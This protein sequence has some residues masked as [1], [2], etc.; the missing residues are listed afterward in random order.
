MAK[1]LTFIMQHEE[2]YNWC[3]AAVA[4]SVGDY[5]TQAGTWKQ[6]AVANLELRRNDCCAAGGDGPCNIYGYLASALNRVH[7]LQNWAIGQRVA[8][9][10]VVGEIDGGRPVCV[11]VAWRGGGA[12]FVA[13]TG[14]SDPD[15]TIAH[16]L[17]QDPL[18][19]YHDIAWS[20]FLDYYK[21]TGLHQGYWTDTYRTRAPEVAQDGPQ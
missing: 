7:C 12:H 5:F 21:P 4:A 6:C 8:F 3:W 17:V 14:Y 20:D 10:V 15:P 1:T 19:Q 11:R 18:F 2:Q 9:D 13:I 16:V